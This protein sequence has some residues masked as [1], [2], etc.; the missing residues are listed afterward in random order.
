VHLDEPIV[1]GRG[2]VD[3]DEDEVVVVVELRPLVELLR[4]LDR[5]W[6]EFEDVAQDLE[7]VL[8][9]PIE[10][11]PEEA[12]AREERRHALAIELH[13]AALSILDDMACPRA[14][15]RLGLPRRQGRIAC[16]RVPG[17][18]EAAEQARANAA[19]A[20][21]PKPNDADRGARAF[22][23]IRSSSPGAGW[24]GAALDRAIA[25]RAAANG[26]PRLEQAL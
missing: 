17:H 1:V 12:A 3:D 14:A 9:R 11:E 6:V 19:L 8:A 10:V 20:L 7:V 18:H 2:S 25:R 4:I 16:L 5:E 23:A 13:F 21:R 22:V 24:A 26:L 15:A